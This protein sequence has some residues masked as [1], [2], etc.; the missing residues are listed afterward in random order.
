MSIIVREATHHDVDWIV[1]ELKSFSD[2]YCRDKKKKLFKDHKYTR[3]EVV[4]PLIERHLFLVAEMD[5]SELVGMIAGLIGTHAFNNEISTLNELFWWVPQG[6]RH[7]R[8]GLMLINEYTRW[9]RENVDWAFMTLETDS[10]VNDRSIIKRG[11]QPVERQFLM[12]G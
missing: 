3:S 6:Y 7:T 12:E 2:F 8:A 5:E 11:Y 10:P 9:G 1:P 4:L